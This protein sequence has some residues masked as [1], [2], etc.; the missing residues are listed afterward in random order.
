MAER[1]GK[2]AQAVTP[3]R[4]LDAE[5]TM[6][7]QRDALGEA[8]VRLGAEHEHLVVLSPDVSLS[9][10]SILFKEAFP[11]RFICTGI[12]EQNTL[13][14]AAGLTSWG[15]VP[16]VALYAVFAA[17]KALDPILNSIAYPN[18]NVKI[19]GTHGGINVG[20]DG[21]TH[22]AISDLGVMRSIANM[23]VLTV[24]DASEVE[25]ALR[26]ALQHSGP[27]YLRLERAPVPDLGLG[28]RPYRIGQGIVLRDGTDLTIIGIG[29]MVSQGLLAADR[30]AAQGISA[31]VI[32]M[33]SL[34]PIDGQL[35]L[36]AAT[37]T[38]GIVT[39]EDHNCHGGLRSAV[40]EVLAAGHAAPL[41]YVALEDC[42]AQSGTCDVLHCTYGL[43]AEHIT[44][45][46]LEL[47]QSRQGGARP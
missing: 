43:D 25:P 44:Q 23:T 47:W 33:R 8:L 7:A 45:A 17:G 6:K 24:A 37:E 34:K 35:I 14:L 16:V 2:H 30:L 15:Y 32:N 39:A 46:C 1:T 22:Q 13:G 36:Q 40:T 21:P 42:F 5:V 20:A 19:I 41:R 11:E 31:R 27:V 10:R 38:A 26:A 28:D 18:L 9:T 29:S 12:A 4:G 3:A